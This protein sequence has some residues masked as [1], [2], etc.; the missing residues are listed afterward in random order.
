M[1]SGLELHVQDVASINFELQIGSVSETVTVS[2]GGLVIDTQ[3][4]SVSTVV[5]RQFAENLPMNGRSFQTLIQLTPG[6]VPT[7]DDSA[8]CGQFSVNGQRA[9]FELLDGGWRERQHRRRRRCISR[10]RSREAR[11]G[12]SA[13]WE[14]QTAWCPLTPCRSF[15][16]RLP[17]RAGIRTDAGR[18]NLD[19]DALRDESVAWHGV[20]LFSKRRSGREQLVCR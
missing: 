1:K 3:D 18:A 19:R 2:A 15:V 13:S 7:S 14:E 8:E 16:S 5:D 9:S 17:L 20:R 6:V 4:A 10:K 12:P 11:S